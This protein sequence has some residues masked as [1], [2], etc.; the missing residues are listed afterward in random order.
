M[1]SWNIK[2]AL[3]GAVVW[4]LWQEDLQNPELNKVVMGQVKE[5]PQLGNELYQ[6]AGIYVSLFFFNLSSPTVKIKT[7]L[8][9]FLQTSTPDLT[10]SMQNH[11]LSL[12]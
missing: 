6:A 11:S 10:T 2:E 9:N 8:T 5:H 7:S 12:F 3:G 1:N 4:L